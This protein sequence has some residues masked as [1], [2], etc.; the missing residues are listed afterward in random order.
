M[1]D[2]LGKNLGVLRKQE[3][4]A[5]AKA[6]SLDLVLLTKNPQATAKILDYGKFIYN[7]QKK[8]KINKKKQLIT[9]NKEI[10]VKPQ[11]GAHDLQVRVK[12][13]QDWLRMGY[14]IRFVIL[15]YGRIGFK[16]ELIEEIYHKFVELVGECGMIQQPLKKVSRILYEAY[17]VANKK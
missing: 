1:I 12:N 7:N 14:R 2:H 9:K 11:I 16:P 6:N 3:A 15:A 10:K 5:L 17:L 8:N 13:A 4:L